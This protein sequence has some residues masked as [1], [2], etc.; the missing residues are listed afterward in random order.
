MT[1]KAPV[2]EVFDRLV[3]FTARGQ[4]GGELNI[5]KG[6][7][8]PIHTGSTHESHGQYVEGGPLLGGGFMPSYSTPGASLTILEYVPNT[9]LAIEVR[10]GPDVTQLVIFELQ[11]AD[12][13]T[14]VTRI[15][16][17]L[18]MSVSARLVSVTLLLP[19]LLVSVPLRPLFRARKMRWFKRYAE[20]AN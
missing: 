18:H 17:V 20:S 6:S 5:P 15:D 4:W 9:R 10:L 14:R 2:E 19:I 1:V 3:D 11:A 7:T 8:W 12:G 16:K 13:G